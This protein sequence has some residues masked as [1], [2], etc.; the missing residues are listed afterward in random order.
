M[1]PSQARISLIVDVFD[2]AGQP[3]NVLADLKPPQLVHAILREFHTQEHL[4]DA[5]EGYYLA[6]VADGE[7][8]D[9]ETSL[10]RQLREGERVRLV[11]RL[12][13]LP[14]GA[15][16]PSQ[17]IYLREQ[18]TNRAY[19]IHWLPAIVGRRSEDQPRNDLVAVDLRGHESGQRVSRRHVRLTERRGRFFVENLSNNPVSLVSPEAAVPQPVGAEPAQLAP[20]DVIR[21]DRSDIEL[22]FIARDAQPDAAQPE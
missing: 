6:R 3:A 8:L 10:G 16:R 19:P 13:E 1:S 15:Q 18:H 7:P 5:A 20:G 17:P 9:D 22:K 14:E 11:E 4:G 21:L 12:A 2:E